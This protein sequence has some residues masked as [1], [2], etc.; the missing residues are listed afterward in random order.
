M[1]QRSDP[2]YRWISLRLDPIHPADLFTFYTATLTS[3]N[4]NVFCRNVTP[5]VC[6]NA[7]IYQAANRWLPWGS[8]K[9]K[10]KQKGQAKIHKKAK[11]T[12]IADIEGQSMA[13]E[14]VIPA[15]T[16]PSTLSLHTRLWHTGT[17]RERVTIKLATAAD[18]LRVDQSLLVIHRVVE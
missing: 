12:S 9:A 1:N 6:A 15:N 11:V 2:L 7:I 3:Y 17:C 8:H 14:E 16:F 4:H 10:R 18:S 13:Q 5:R